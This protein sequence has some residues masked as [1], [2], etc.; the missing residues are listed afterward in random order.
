LALKPAAAVPAALDPDVAAGY[1]ALLAGDARRAAQAYEKAVQSD[2]YNVDA[3][4][5]LATAAS[6]L[7]NAGLAARHFQEALALDPRN[8]YALAGLVNLSSDRGGDALEQALRSRLAQNPAAA[9]LHFALGNLHAAHQRWHDAQQAYFDAW[10]HEPE[11]ADYA[12]NLAV[13]LDHLRQ[14]PLASQYYAKALALARTGTAQF[15]LDAAA[16]RLAE[17]AAAAP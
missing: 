16:R 8:G 3:H 14:T 17:L 6:R 5:G 4:L 12:F 1:H 10:Q 9:A 7:G 15:D 2:A 13:S 11:R